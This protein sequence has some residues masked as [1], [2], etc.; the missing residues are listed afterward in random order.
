[1]ASIVLNKPSGG[2]L[3][4]SPEDGT[5]NETVTIPSVGVGKVLQVLYDET[6]TVGVM[7]AAHPALTDVGCEITIT[8]S[9]ASSKILILGSVGGIY[10]DSAVNGFTRTS[11]VKDGSV[12]QNMDLIIGWTG[13]TTKASGSSSGAYLDSPN[14]TSPVTYKLQI[15]NGSNNTATIRW[16]N[17]NGSSGVLGSSSI[18]VME[19]AA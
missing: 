10:K 8:P 17:Y 16:N 5:S 4:L 19:V 13:T 1:M 15:G 12:L 18:T 14:T 2:Q 3:T 7:S 6:T 11:I 9:S